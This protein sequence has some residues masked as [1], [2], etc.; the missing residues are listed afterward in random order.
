MDNQR[1]LA[2]ILCGDVVGYTR[3]M[4]DNEQDTLAALQVTR[5]IV[6]RLVTQHDGHVNDTTGDSVLAEFPSVVR[7]VQ[8]AQAIQ[9][10]L[11]E[12]NEALPE[13]R[14]MLLRIGINLGDVISDGDT[15]YGDG[16]N[17]AARAQA[18]ADP[19]GINLCGPAWEQVRDKLDLDVEPMGQQRFKNV[20]EPVT[21]FR[22]LDG[23]SGLAKKPQ[24][25]KRMPL[26]AAALVLLAIV[27]GVLKW[28]QAVDEPEPGRATVPIVESSLLS[29]V[30]PQAETMASAPPT[31]VVLPF[32][33]LGNAPEQEY[34]GDGIAND[35]ITDLSRL[36]SLRVIASGTALTFKGG[37]ASPSDIGK[38]LD[39]QYVVEGTVQL[40]GQQLRIN[41]HIVDIATGFDVWGERYE[42]TVDNLFELQ[43]RVTRRIVD[44][45][46]VHATPEEQRNLGR[47]ATHSF[48][49]YE[50]FLTGLQG[51]RERSREGFTRSE[52]AYRRAIELDPGFARAYSGLAVVI[53]QSYWQGWS[54][55]PSETLV[56]AISLARKAV[57][58]DP[59]SPQVYWALGYVHLW[60]REYELAASAVEQAIELAP[61]YADGFGL[62]AYINNWRGQYVQAEQ[63]IRKGMELNPY[64]TFDYPWNLGR[65]YYGRGRYEEAAREFEKALEKNANAQTV[66]LFLISS[67]VRLDRLNDAEWEAEQVTANDPQLT[68]SQVGDGLPFADREGLKALLDDLR[69]AGLPE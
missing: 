61:N 56:R 52:A 9:A 41:V 37:K 17:V 59:Q 28:W 58:L 46:A 48:E 64:Y 36:R 27:F 21:C 69:A 29:P 26:L 23:A 39:V 49:A 1:K 60:R 45:V 18:A 30:Q 33:I 6:S 40:A 42:G 66:R 15:I 55:N 35:I 10:E 8:C 7:A 43:D 4:A 25:V 22:V 11:K 57:E 5:E 34:L 65:S 44:S 20:A 53:A 47:A 50:L 13:T 54:E 14:R 12:R 24:G 68:V 38:Q 3:L 31:V 19:G 62:L 63:Q 32:N 51:F 67:Y 16:I 2:A